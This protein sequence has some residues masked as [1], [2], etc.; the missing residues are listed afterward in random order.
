MADRPGWEPAFA[1]FNGFVAA[2]RV[3]PERMKALL[4]TH[5]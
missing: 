3:E 5:P 4:A 2:M 1:A